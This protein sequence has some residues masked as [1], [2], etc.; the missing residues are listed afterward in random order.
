MERQARSAAQPAAPAT[1][2]PLVAHTTASARVAPAGIQLPA[3][4]AH[5]GAAT[6]TSLAHPG[7]GR[8]EGEQPG[9]HGGRAHGGAHGQVARARALGHLPPLGT[10]PAWPPDGCG[11]WIEQIERGRRRTG[12]RR[13][14]LSIHPSSSGAGEIGP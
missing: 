11:L 4:R 12:R 5:E 9:V 14:L 3:G 8:T 6:S 7:V 2:V 13:H 1:A 10:T